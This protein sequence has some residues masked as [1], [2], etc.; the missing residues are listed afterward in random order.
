MSFSQPVNFRYD[1]SAPSFLT[2][3]NLNFDYP[4]K[5]TQD[6]K[7]VIHTKSGTNDATI[8]PTLAIVDEVP[9][10]TVRSG[11]GNTSVV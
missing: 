5:L 10:A 4:H 9:S 3:M 1:I 2:N 7:Y 11:V 8:A 6:N